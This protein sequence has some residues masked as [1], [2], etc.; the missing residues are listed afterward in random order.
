MRQFVIDQVVGTLMAMGAVVSLCFST[1]CAQDAPANP[2][3]DASSAPQA[4]DQFAV[5]MTAAD[6]AKD[7]D[8]RV[9]YLR[10]A[11]SLR[12]DHPDNIAIEFRIAIEL[13]Q[14]I[15]PGNMH[16]PHKTEGLA[17]LEHIVKSYRNMDYYSS[18]PV[19]S[20]GSM[21]DMVPKAAILAAGL[22]DVLNNDQQ[23][24]REFVIFAMKQL[25]EKYEKRVSD[26]ATLPL[27]KPGPYVDREFGPTMGSKSHWQ[28][29]VRNVEKRRAAAAE[30]NVFSPIEMV[31]VN[32]AVKQFGYL[33]GQQKPDEVPAVMGEI[34]R[35]FPGTPMAKAAQE[36]ADRAAAIAARE[37]IPAQAPNDPPPRLNSGTA[38]PAGW[39]EPP[40][41]SEVAPPSTGKPAQEA[42][43]HSADAG[44]EARKTSSHEPK[45]AFES[46]VNVPGPK[47]NDEVVQTQTPDT[48][49]Q[50]SAI[51]GHH[52]WVTWA[53]VGSVLVVSAVLYAF[54]RRNH[55]RHRN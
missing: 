22:E 44:R 53:V 15:D 26:W 27:P 54:G 5:V 4:V 6:K 16:G 13:T 47:V 48:S 19:N 46:T 12:S 42:L 3:L 28:S 32:A 30:G 34:V 9:G 43:Q 33:H 45:S 37:G 11:L 29:S 36:H 14:R 7:R 17:V 41:A 35:M 40:K 39:Q 49:K 38:E 18:E 50:A 55:T 21:Q 10:K 23:K 20:S 51:A 52:H 24:A 1:C 2:A 8:S 25:E 31:T